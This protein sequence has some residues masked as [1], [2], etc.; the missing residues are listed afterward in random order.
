MPKWRRRSKSLCPSATFPKTLSTTKPSPN[1]ANE[2][3][4]EV[5][6]RLVGFTQSDPLA[7]KISDESPVGKALIGKHV[8]D[9]I[10]VEA[11]RGKV[12]FEILEVAKKN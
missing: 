12:S 8:G 6:Y 11:P 10:E 9:V 4:D 2:T 3:G 5:T 1:R 7:G